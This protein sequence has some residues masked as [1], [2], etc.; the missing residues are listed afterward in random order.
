[1]DTVD[2]FGS[3][4]ALLSKSFK[5]ER[6]LSYSLSTRY[7]SFLLLTATCCFFSTLLG[8][9][10]DKNAKLAGSLDKDSLGIL[11]AVETVI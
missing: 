2:F 7:V 5:Y 3:E 6:N 9:L 11:N 8:S 4:K 1:M 10:G